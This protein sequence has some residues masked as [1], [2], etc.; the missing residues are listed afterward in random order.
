MSKSTTDLH[1]N[2]RAATERDETKVNIADTVQRDLELDFVFATCRR[3]AAC[4]RWGAAT[5]M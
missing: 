1:W 4:S 5:G 3:R 2:A